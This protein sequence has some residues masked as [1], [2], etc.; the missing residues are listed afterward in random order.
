MQKDLTLTPEERAKLEATGHPLLSLLEEADDPGKKAMAAGWLAAWR[1]P[2]SESE[3]AK[4][5]FSKVQ[6]LVAP[7][8]KLPPEQGDLMQFCGFPTDMTRVSP[9]FPIAQH[10]LHDRTL[11]KD[12][13]ITAANWGEIRYTGPKLSI[14]EEDALMA[15][16]A[17]VES[18][19]SKYKDNNATHEGKR[20]YA[21]KGPA[22]P[23]LKILGC[24]RRPSA[25][26]YK[27]LI[28]SLELLTTT[29][30]K[31]SVSDGKTK[32]GKRK[33]RYSTMSAML[34]AVTWDDEKKEL[35]AAVNPYFYEMYLSGRYT[36]LDIQKRMAIGGSIAKAMYRFV[37]SHKQKA[38][39]WEGNY[40]VLAM[41]LNMDMEQPA[42]TLRRFLK[43]AI[44]ELVKQAVL[45]NQ[46]HMKGDIVTLY[47]A[48]PPTKTRALS[49]A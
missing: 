27:R 5:I 33:T 15:L 12:F 18:V 38:P 25:K 10:E 28:N 17:V 4:A 20:T 9:F 29:G 21:Y 44:T 13:L 37:Q 11:L 41:T 48:D 31:L 23:L 2:P 32:G 35:Y 30:V 22:L 7:G 24:N 16:L 34:S 14:Y 43:R 45:T 3:E 46:S 47:R 40:R 6:D 39:I 42:F 36:L 49:H 8:G 1:N 19:S 26:D